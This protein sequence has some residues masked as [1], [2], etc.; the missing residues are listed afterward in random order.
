[1]LCHHSCA[2]PQVQAL[3]LDGYRPTAVPAVSAPS[4]AISSVL[5]KRLF[6]QQWG[7]APAASTADPLATSTA[8]AAASSS[9]TGLPSPGRGATVSPLNPTASRQLPLL[10]ALRHV[11]HHEGIL[12][13]W[14]GNLATILHRMPYSAVNFSAFEMVRR[15]GAQRPDNG[16]RAVVIYPCYPSRAALRLTRACQA[17]CIRH[18][19]GVS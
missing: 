15:V 3:S 12:S 9:S 10:S 1:M 2:P 16:I 4:P 13:L 17:Q 19:P 7:R 18:Q 11:V 6:P 5:P 8:A 14:R